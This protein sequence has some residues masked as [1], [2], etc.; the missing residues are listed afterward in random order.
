MAS[1]K[2]FYKAQQQGMQRVINDLVNARNELSHV[3]LHE[4]GAM[5]PDDKSYWYIYRQLTNVLISAEDQY[6][7]LSAMKG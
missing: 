3:M 7:A 6:D 4:R 2:N 1:D 5:C